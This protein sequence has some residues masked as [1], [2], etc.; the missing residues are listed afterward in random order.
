[1][2]AGFVSLHRKILDWEWYKDSKTKDVFIHLL[3]KANHEDKN[4]QGVVIKRG[5][6]V[7]SNLTLATELGMTV[8][9]V[10]TALAKLSGTNK[11]LTNREKKALFPT[12]TA[13]SQKNDENE[14]SKINK[15]STCEITIKSTNRFSLITL[16]NYEVYQTPVTNKSTNKP[17]GNQQTTNKQL[18]TNNN[19][20]NTNNKIINNTPLQEYLNLFNELFGREFQSTTGRERKLKLRLQKFTLEQILEAT[21][22]L[23]KSKWHKGENDNGWRADPDFLIRSDEQIDKWLNTK[24]KKPFVPVVEPAKPVVYHEIDEATRQKNLEKMAEIKSNLFRKK[25]ELQ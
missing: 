2:N 16:V 18:T 22:N 15:Q 19:I 17:T 3:L 9:N 14:T 1:M 25:D 24:S 11:Q 6:L 20:N 4:W 12:A 10:R 5:Q 21:R 13:N 23:S 8:Q 7:T